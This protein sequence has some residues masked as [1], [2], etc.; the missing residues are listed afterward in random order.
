MI[1]EMDGKKWKGRNMGVKFAMDK[2]DYKDKKSK[3]STK[4]G[5][6]KDQFDENIEIVKA[7]GEGPAEGKELEEENFDDLDNLVMQNV[8]GMGDDFSFEDEFDEDMEEEG[9]ANED[10]QFTE[11]DLGDDE[12]DLDAQ[13]LD[14]SETN[15]LK[16]RE[17]DLKSAKNKK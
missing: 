5:T 14:E 12:N 4:N 1:K 17:Q 9:Q 13:G 3:M 10:N 11:L 8:M 15:K 7:D 2:R 6:G 16:I